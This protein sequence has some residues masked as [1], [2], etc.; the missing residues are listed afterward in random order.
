MSGYYPM[1]VPSSRDQEKADLQSLTNRMQN[2]IGKVKKLR[3]DSNQVDSSALLNSIRLL[4]DEGNKV[5]SIYEKELTN[6]RGQLQDERAARTQAE[7]QAHRNNQLA[8]DFQDRL[9]VETQRNRALQSE[10]DDAHK[11]SAQKDMDCQ[12]LKSKCGELMKRAHDLEDDVSA[13]TRQNEDMQRKLDREIV[14]RQQAEDKHR[15]L[16]RKQEFDSRL[17]QEESKE[18]QLRLDDDANRILQLETKVRELA[19]PDNTLHEALENMRQAAERDLQN[20]KDETESTYHKNLQELKHQMGKDSENIQKLGNENKSL[21]REIDRLIEELSST[22]CKLDQAEK[23]TANLMDTLRND[24]EKNTVHIRALEENQRLLQDSLIQKMHEISQA[25]GTKQPIRA[26]LES[27]K[28]MLDEEEKKF[29]H[30]ATTKYPLASF[31]GSEGRPRTVDSRA[32]RDRDVLNPLTRSRPA[33]VPATMG[34][35]RDYFDSIFQDMNRSGTIKTKVYSKSNSAPATRTPPMSHDFTTATSSTTGDLKILEINEDGKFVRLFNSSPGKDVDV[36]GFMIQQNIGGH[37]VAVYRFEPRTRFR[38]GA[39]M[40][41]WSASSLAKHQPPTDFLWKEQHRWG[42]GPECTT[43]LCKPNGHA[44]A[45]TTAAHRFS[46]TARKYDESDDKSVEE[47]KGEESEEGITNLHPEFEVEIDG[48]PVTVLKR[49]K[50]DPPSL[51]PAKHPHGQYSQHDTHPGAGE[52]RVKTLGND[53]SSLVRQS[54]SQ[55]TRPDAAPGE[56]YAGYGISATRTGSAPLRLSS[57]PSSS[58]SQG[59]IRF[60]ARPFLPPHNQDD[61][62]MNL[63]AGQQHVAFKPP[64]PNPSYAISS[65]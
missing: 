38:A 36:G 26:E 53:G 14:G 65:W 60:S 27:L 7:T 57:R 63:I 40:T 16:E 13:L 44:I 33:S 62:N 9:A 5:K 50:Q 30:M 61:V 24:R 22:K 49:D 23:Q 42:T 59:S 15:A 25:T 6:T 56:L 37:P 18:Q 19:R 39:V 43:I 45:W 20:F 21:E 34:Q 64:M 52:T 35:G 47:E 28:N 8:N 48:K 54:R 11:L 46:K 2:Y 12:Q 55:I 58:T 41:V 29:R 31:P 4:E 10:V 51:A 32:G 3:E 1:S 17:Q